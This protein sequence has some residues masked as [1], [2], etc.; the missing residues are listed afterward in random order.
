MAH[1]ERKHNRARNFW[2]RRIQMLMRDLQRA[3]QI[4]KNAEY[5]LQFGK[6]VFKRSQLCIEPSV[7]QLPLL[8]VREFAI[9]SNF[10]NSI[11][12]RFFYEF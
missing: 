2:K 4:R 3:K 1:A 6:F 8:I 5:L 12:S 9:F 11:K 10:N 7:L